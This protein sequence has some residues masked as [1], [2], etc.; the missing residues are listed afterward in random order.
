MGEW[1]AVEIVDHNKAVE[2]NT[3]ST[4]ID[5]CPILR[6]SREEDSTI[7]LQWKENAGVLIYK[8]RQPKPNHPG[9]WDS[10]GSQ[11]GETRSFVRCGLLTAV[12]EP[13][14]AV[15]MLQAVWWIATT[16]SSRARCR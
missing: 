10:A 16:F 9:F 15:F 5:V 4:V 3:V 11:N 14:D 12:A 1:Y 7:R 13:S 2:H 8:F 6:L